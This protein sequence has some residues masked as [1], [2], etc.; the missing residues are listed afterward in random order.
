MVAK[1]V[2]AHNVSRLAIAAMA[3]LLLLSGAAAAQLGLSG[4]LPVPGT[5]IPFGAT[6]LTSPGLSPALDG[7]IGI[8]GNGTTCSA[9]GSSSS[10]MSGTGA[11][12][13]GGG[14]G[15]GTST[16]VSSATCDATYSN[17]TSSA[18]TLT[19]PASPSG[20]TPA[21]IP[22]GSF[23]TNNAGISPSVAVP[24]PNLSVPITTS[25][26]PPSFGAIMPCSIAG[27]SIPST[28]C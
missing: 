6:G 21:G 7:T 14:I 27:S 12:Y 15:T 25:L 3:T 10:G 13:D 8:T 26:L 22:L 4:N 18:A 9:V 2:I 23:E 5:G 19:L 20:A 16:I 24:A 1:I 28:A 17:G 11:N